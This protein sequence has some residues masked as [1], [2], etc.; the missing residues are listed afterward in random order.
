MASNYQ[1]SHLR[2][3]RDSNS[4]LRG[5]RRE[6]Y[7]SAIQYLILN[8]YMFLLIYLYSHFSGGHDIEENLKV[9]DSGVIVLNARSGGQPTYFSVTAENHVGLTSSGLSPVMVVD[10]TEP[11]EGELRCPLV[12]NTND[13]TCSWSGA[14]DAESGL[15]K[16]LFGIGSAEGIDN[17]IGFTDV[18]KEET[19]ITVTNNGEFA[20]IHNSVYYATLSAVNNVGANTFIYSNAMR[21]DATPPDF[22]WVVELED[23]VMVDATS[24]IVYNTD[25]ATISADMDVLCQRDITKVE[26]AWEEF[27]DEESGIDYYEVALGSTPGGTQ[28]QQF[29]KVQG[30]SMR[31][32]FYPVDLAAVRQV[33]ASVRGFNGVGLFSV[34]V[35]NGVYISRLSAGLLP[36][37]PLL[38]LDGNQ[39]D[40]M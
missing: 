10:Q 11:E 13:I 33:F 40:D 12:I 16:F 2:L 22:G 19:S 24:G 20:L 9:N 18:D 27:T 23:F 14:M 29:T 5:G 32:T 6:C 25:D 17:I 8:N 35:S 34:A 7:H 30:E 15:N 21:V 1:L 26:I 38:V 3:G 37:S 36:L 39:V 28:I 31:Y 4:D